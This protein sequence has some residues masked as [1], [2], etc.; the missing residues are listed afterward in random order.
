MK[1]AEAGKSIDEIKAKLNKKIGGSVVV[2]E[3]K[4]EKGETPA[5]DKIWDKKGVIDIPNE[6]ST[7]K[8]YFVSGVVGPE[9]KSLKEARGI[10]TSDYQNYL[11]KA[12]IKSLHDKYPVVVNE[13]TVK[14]LFK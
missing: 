7:F 12:W 5:M 11:E 10:A 9:P 13:E 3:Q 1:M 14:T 8:F 6:N 4:T 2:T